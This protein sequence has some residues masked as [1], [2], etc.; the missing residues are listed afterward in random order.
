MP[1]EEQSQH[2]REGRAN[3]LWTG[4]KAEGLIIALCFVASAMN[5]AMMHQIQSI[6]RKAVGGDPQGGPS[7]HTTSSTTTGT[8]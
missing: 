3:C 6:S 1:V 5:W 4:E 7:L 2:R 8:L